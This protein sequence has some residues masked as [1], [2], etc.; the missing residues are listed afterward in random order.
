MRRGFA[1]LVLG[2]SLILATVAWA[3][4]VMN[5][6]VLDPGRSERLADQLFENDTLRTALVSRL[7]AGLGQA[8]PADAP[9]VPDQLLEQAASAALDDPA[10]QAVVRDGIV[11]THRNALE[12]NV[13]PVTVDASALGAAAR[14][15][16]IEVRP[17]LDPL[18][19]ALPPVEITLP[20]NGLSRLG[21]VKDFVER[22]TTIAAVTALI[23]ALSALLITTNR[24]AVL[25]R[26]AFW[27]FGAAAFW[28]VVGFAI[29][30]LANTIAPTSAA[31]VAA[32]IDV[33]FGAMIGPAV[34]LG[35]VGA[36]LLLSSMLWSNMLDR[37]PAAVL[38]PRGA[39]AAPATTV[40]ERPTVG[41]RS[42]M[43]P[44]RPG[45]VPAPAPQAEA[46]N[47]QP[48]LVDPTMVQPVAGEPLPLRPVAQ[49]VP[50]STPAREWVEGVGYVDEEP[51]EDNRSS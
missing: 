49:D 7:A 31:I 45:Q 38:Q 44:P 35:I 28:L 43:R 37:R 6:T 36:G 2:L 20:T 12:G 30:W 40:A 32:I 50:P 46:P 27:A 9:A 17:E 19:P 11:Q 4:F 34:V 47:A 10:V 18:V 15:S 21:A 5:R 16:L 51:A 26:V 33:F 25:R 3:G 8:L 48:P 23:G 22:A 42:N 24:P 39:A 13:E 14:A 29:P 1:G 41:A